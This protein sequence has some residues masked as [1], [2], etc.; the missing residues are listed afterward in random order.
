MEENK[1]PDGWSKVDRCRII[2][3]DQGR[4]KILGVCKCGAPVWL[5]H[6]KVFKRWFLG[7][8]PACRSLV[9]ARIRRVTVTHDEA[10]EDTGRIRDIDTLVAHLTDVAVREIDPV[11]Y[12]AAEML[13]EFEDVKT[14]NIAGLQ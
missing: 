13:Q 5:K 7:R 6:G 14:G 11:M 12:D 10:A 8:C 3:D 1:I 4:M 2:F 9:I